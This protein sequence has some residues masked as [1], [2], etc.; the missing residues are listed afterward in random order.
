MSKSVAA[1][2]KVVSK[3]SSIYGLANILNR[4]VS[5]LLLPLY[6][7]YLAPADYGTLDLLY[8]T[9]AFIGMILD[10]G[11][12]ASLARFYFDSEEQSERNLAISSAFYGFG[13][14]SSLLILVFVS[15][16]GYL[17]D[18]VF[19]ATS[20]L[21]FLILFLV[22]L[23]G[24]A[25]MPLAHNYT[26]LLIL[27]LVSLSL[28]IY[29]NVAYNYLRIRQKSLKLTIVSV[30]RLAMQLTL[31]I[32]FIVV[33]GWGV[34]GILVSMVIANS[35]L[36]AY[37]IPN[38]IKE[39]G[40]KFSWPKLKSMITYGLPLIPSNILAYIVNVSDRFF[41]NAYVGLTETGLYTL[42]YR[43]GILVNEFVTS[44]FG[45]IWVPRRFEMFQKGDAERIFAR[46]FTYFCAALFFI[47][48]G[49]S[50]ATKEVIEIMSEKA[51]WDAH[52]VVPVIVLAYIV[53][54]FQMHFNTGILYK[55]KTKYVLYINVV[56]AAAN[57]GLN[58]WMISRWGMWGA[59]WATLICFVLKVAI[60]YVVGNRL[61]KIAIEWARVIKLTVIAAI[62]YAL[63]SMIDVG[64]PVT[65]L[66]LKCLGCLFYPLIL[67]WV[68]F[69]EP[70]ELKKGWELVKPYLGKVFPRFREQTAGAP[71]PE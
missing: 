45:Q 48:L 63:L 26:G 17:S 22:K 30:V 7:Q 43:F 66:V 46:I 3:H 23:T 41:V 13:V 59:A 21:N 16:S 8:F 52:L 36:V 51:Y 25:E 69:F 71:P 27:S 39:V 29:I 58:F 65:T 5:F 11:I 9:T 40:L 38:T 37:L 57:I 53:S 70:D 10:M 20:S 47:G 56:T 2:L 54:S 67:Y 4:I 62:M 14:G 34:A 35:V 50:V 49:I 61:V 15:L 55:K 42:G 31:N 32:F 68:K 44:P 60:V 24:S 6:T 12:T 19:R 64:T 28:D 1:E 18:L 33:L